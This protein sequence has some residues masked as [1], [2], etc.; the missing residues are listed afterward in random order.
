MTPAERTKLLTNVAQ[1]KPE[2]AEQ[3][4][5]QIFT[6]EDLA[7]IH[8]KGLQALLRELPQNVL[9]MALR[10]ATQEFKD[11]LYQNMSTRSS[12]LIDEELKNLGPQ[13]LS[14]VQAA[15]EKILQIAEEMEK[16]G[17]LVLSNMAADGS[18]TE[19]IE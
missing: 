11:H 8:Q 6:F 9:V 13:K 3:I 7:H 1:Q 15:Q 10:N 4:R 19:I 16:Q 18:E 12:E 5:K 14:S 17:K 2:L